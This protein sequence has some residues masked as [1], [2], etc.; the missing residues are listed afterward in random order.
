MT[1]FII[2]RLCQSVVILAIT[3]LI[4]FAGVYA[5][6]D[7]IEILVP[8]DATPAEIAQ[9]VQSLGL[10]LPLYQQYL[11]FVANA[12]H[13]DLGNS[14]V[15]NQPAIQLI[16][17][18]LPATLELACVALL[19][20]LAIGLPLGLVAGLKPDS[21]LDRGIMTGSILGFSLP[22]FWQGIMLVLIFSVTLGWLPS[23]GRGPTGEF[24]GMRTS[25]ASWDGIRHLILPALNLALFKIALIVRLTRSGV[26]E[27]MP[28]DYVKFAR[29]KGLRESRV[30]G[31]HV[32]KNILIPIVTVVGMEFGS[33]IAFATVTE[34][35]FAW[36]GVGKLIIDSI[37]K[38]DRPVVVAYLLIVVTMFIVLN[39]LVDILYSI[40]DPRV[41]VG[42]SQ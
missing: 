17:Q 20:A 28:L 25:L 35:I 18:R 42:A 1:A 23:T 40:L 31:M 36:P 41:R 10:D 7:P 13:G 39:L 16:L 32:L 9:A 21:A 5:I 12:L 2:R 34:T 14:F 8:A 30:I 22:N 6:G 37:M 38:L 4:V 15:F 33:L 29:A 3:S 11:K 24:L 27:T 26:R 19:L